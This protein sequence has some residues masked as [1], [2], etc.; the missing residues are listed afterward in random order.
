MKI[1]IAEDEETLVKVFQEK[2]EREHFSVEVITKGDAVL[3]A[4][5][6][7]MPDII[8]LDI[9]LPKK[10]GLVILKELK[11]SPDLKH[12]PVIIVS[13]L[14]EDEQIKEALQNGAVDYL[15]KAQHP[16]NEIV[17]KVNNA[18]AHLK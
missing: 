15:V 4:V 18:I 11:A 12:I 10:T 1:L 3:S 13:N 6:K 16:I 9:I 17:E 5:K 14:G 8:L 7:F 2:F